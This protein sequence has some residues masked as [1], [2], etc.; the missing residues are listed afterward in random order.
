MVFSHQSVTSPMS[1]NFSTSSALCIYF[2]Y[3]EEPWTY[4]SVLLYLP[5]SRRGGIT[6][7]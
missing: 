6:Q 2:Y 7:S 1:R 4:A 5:G 3:Y